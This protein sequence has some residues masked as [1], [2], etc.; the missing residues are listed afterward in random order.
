MIKETYGGQ[1]TYLNQV[2]LYDDIV[3]NKYTN[4][5]VNLITNEN[6]TDEENNESEH[7]HTESDNP[8]TAQSPRKKNMY[9]LLLLKGT[10]IIF[11]QIMLG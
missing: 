7:I 3:E 10:N 9:F 1:K 11:L 6:K 5:S 4:E 8:S 2:F